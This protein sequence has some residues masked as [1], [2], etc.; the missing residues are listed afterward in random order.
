M[1]L[2]KDLLRRFFKVGAFLGLL[3]LLVFVN[4]TKALYAEPPAG[5][6]ESQGVPNDVQKLN[7]A[8]DACNIEGEQNSNCV[9]SNASSV[10]FK[11]G[12]AKGDVVGGDGGLESILAGILKNIDIS[13][14]RKT[15]VVNA[16]GETETYTVYTPGAIGGLI[17]LTAQLYQHPPASSVEYIADTINN[18]KHPF[19]PPAYAQGLGFSSLAPVLELW[20]LFRNVAYFFFVVIF[21]VVGFLI[22]IR[23]KIGSQAAVTVQQMLPKLVLSLILV[24]FSY[25]IAGLL[26][27]IMNIIIFLMI[28]MFSTLTNVF[29]GGALPGSGVSLRDLAFKNDIFTN[30]FSLVTNGV[31]GSVAGSM[32]VIVQNILVNLGWSQWVTDV[33]KLATNVIFTLVLVIVILVSLFRTF[34]ALL[35]AYISIFFAV[36]T[37]PIQLLLGALPGQNTFQKWVTSI[38]ENLLVFPAIILLIFIAYFFAN[39]TPDS[40]TA[41]GFSAPQLGS[42]QGAQGFAVYQALIA[43]GVILAMPEVAKVAKGLMKGEVGVSVGDLG[44]NLQAGWK[45]GELVPGLG[46]TNIAGPGGIGKAYTGWK[47]TAVG[48]DAYRKR[49]QE[50]MLLSGKTDLPQYGGVV[51]VLEKFGKKGQVT[52]RQIEQTQKARR[53]AETQLP[54]GAGGPQSGNPPQPDRF[55]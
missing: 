2:R 23:A 16:N 30:G 38:V 40:Q 36:I 4:K 26:I 34:I 17:N 55:L 48:T 24:T 53:Q 22:M 7:Q 49:Q 12:Q 46:F 21:V 33:L 47:N 35:T 45:G 20:K 9:F 19:A 54:G 13:P 11:E 5:T 44:K 28:G 25:A 3:F 37:A 32:G 39:R 18:L 41:G 43:L 14:P 10:V 50:L 6:T 31:A 27:D 15:T 1:I 52:T 8:N 51:G 29:P 42:N